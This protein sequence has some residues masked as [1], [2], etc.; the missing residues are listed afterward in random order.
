MEIQ[1]LKDIVQIFA[2]SI[3]VIL[4]FH[5]LRVPAIVGFLLTGV[6]IGPHGL[7]LISAVHEVEILA[8]IGVVL[9]L[10]TIGI[11]FSLKKLM[12]I[13]KAVLLGG[14]VQVVLT[15][16]AS[17]V[18]VSFLKFPA[19]KAVFF[20][21]L[22][23][24][25]S[26]AIVLKVLQDRAEII[27]PHGQTAMA[28][29]IFQDIV[30]VFMI[31]ATPILAGESQDLGYALLILGL[32]V[33]G[34]ILLTVV[35][36]KWVV[37]GV[38]YQVARTRSREL[39]LLSIVVICL[40]VA[41]LTS[42]I[43]LSLAMGAFLA[44]LIISES[45]Y[46]HHAFSQIVPF[47]D[48]F[49]SFFFVSVGMLLDISYVLANPLI[50]IA[51]VAGLLVLKALIAGFVGTLLGLSFRTALLVGF[52]LAQV[53]EFSF[54]LS[55]FGL[56]DGLISANTYQLFLA[57][58]VISMAATPF[59]IAAAPR[60]ADLI[61]KLPLPDRIAA[62]FYPVQQTAKAE[63]K[64]HLIIVGFGVN[65]RNVARAAK[66]S[67][68]PYVIIEMN[69][70]TVRTEQN[71]GE[72]IF[73]GDATREAVLK[74]AGIETARVIVVAIPDAAATGR[75]ADLVQLL[76]SNVH[77]IIRTRFLHEV[78]RLYQLGA[79]EII[80]EEF[81][82]SIQIFSRVLQQFSVSEDRIEKV[83]AEIR[84]ECYG[85]FRKTAATEDLQARLND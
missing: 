59:I 15:I 11:E 42:S 76:N 75:I 63:R 45:E 80:P 33:A 35:L 29:L 70:A 72:A 69:P 36:A 31:L 19:N 34:I 53:G 49:T 60:L 22:I 3:V 56:E 77:V 74:H 50:I 61:L 7:G 62:G 17:A 12:Q 78:D 6:I 44:G 58:S 67:S 39:F 27:S 40:A 71:K 1:I 52:S 48:L 32:K 16:L 57:A 66:I 2:I 30:I 41:W 82:T 18:I 8:E 23:A 28:I 38:L 64:D 68:I 5:R 37:H 14:S 21:F 84:S 51:V 55:R 24:L 4:L 13:K 20:G 54:I 9:L 26:T 46:S 79:D 43:G 25:S 65:G 81:E 73:Y 85:V 47:R 10:F 83:I